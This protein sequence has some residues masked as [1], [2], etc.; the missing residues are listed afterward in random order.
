MVVVDKRVKN[1][2]EKKP[3]EQKPV[4]IDEDQEA[5]EVDD[6][7]EVKPSET[8]TMTDVM[9]V[10]TD[11]ELV[12]KST[13][14]EVDLTQVHSK[15]FKGKSFYLN[16][17]LSATAVIKLKNQITTMMGKLTENASEA[18]FVITEEAK[19]LPQDIT[20][21]ILKSLWVHECYELEALIPTTRYKL[22]R[23]N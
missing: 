5:I 3:E 8:I 14:S 12:M 23:L 4:I 10:S 7:M 20:G 15:I 13:G 9:D 18:D 21:D 1:G 11:D 19:R 16:S 22:K 2:D 6:K 17:D